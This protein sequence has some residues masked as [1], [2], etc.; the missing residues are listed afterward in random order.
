MNNIRTYLLFALV[1]I[2]YTSMPVL[3]NA[4]EYELTSKIGNFSITFPGEPTLTSDVVESAVGD[5]D[6]HSYI[7]DGKEESAYLVAYID[8]PADMVEESDDDVLLESALEGAIESWGFDVDEVE[9]QTKWHSGYKSIYI[10]E[11]KDNT[12]AVYEVMLVGNRLYQLAIL[13]Y[14]EKIKKKEISAFFESFTLL[15]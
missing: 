4:Q 10:I 1:A 9:K 11:S 12:Y 7:Y 5:L 6:L 13:Q 2:L 8:Y 14:N 15:Q 3:L